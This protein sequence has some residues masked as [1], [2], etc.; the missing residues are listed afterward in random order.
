MFRFKLYHPSFN[1]PVT[2]QNDP[3]GWDAE[4]K[5]I[6]RD[7]VLHGVFVKYNPELKFVKD[8][9]ALINE[10][11]NSYGIEAEITLTVERKNVATRAWELQYEG[12][13]E[14]ITFKTDRNFTTV[15]TMDTGFYQKFKNRQDVKVNLQAVTDQDGN[16]M[17]SFADISLPLH[18][19]TIR[20]DSVNRTIEATNVYTGIATGTTYYLLYSFDNEITDELGE[21]FTY[22]PQLST[23]DPVANLKHYFVVKDNGSYE[24]NIRIDQYMSCAVAINW[25]VKW[26]LATGRVGNYTITQIGTTQSVFNIAADQQF[27]A[28]ITRTLAA[29]DEVYL[30]A[31]VVINASGPAT[32]T[33]NYNLNTLRYSEFSVRGSTVSDSSNATATLIHDVWKRV[34]RS[35]TGR[36]NSFKSDYYGRTEDGYAADGAGSLRAIT[37]GEQ[38]RGFSIS[39]YPIYASAKNLFDSCSAID[40]VGMGLEKVN[41]FNRIAVEPLSYFYRNVKAM[42][43]SFVNDI[44]RSVAQEYLFNEVEAGYNI[45]NNRGLQI[46]NLDEVNAKRTYSLPIARVKKKL[47]LIS[48]YIASGYCIEFARR[49]ASKKTTDAEKDKENFIIQLR[50]SPALVPEKNEAASQS[51]VIDTASSYNARLSPMQNLV[52][53]GARIRGGLPNQDI[54]QMSFGEGNNEATT[55]V[56]ANTFN[57]K[58]IDVASLPKPFWKAEYYEFM[59]APSSQDWAAFELQPY[60]FIEFS[61]NNRDYVKGWLISAKPD[62]D[63]NRVHFKLLAAL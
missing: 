51:N 37:S 36:E 58:S 9:R 6:E 23:L 24:F 39:T 49:L 52:R 60:G 41:G 31:T 38:L 59:A 16:A 53:N 11:F 2:L 14:M 62:A 46:N 20:K 21:R 42:R 12:I 15:K 45:W 22:Q 61:A 40:G 43:L 56:G 35:C 10:L 3:M 27:T 32:I 55:I 1:K 17:P 29:N 48:P 13:L 28:T 63:S 57:E 47:T 44:Q 34:V 50:R 33:H 25:E 7:P 54:I 19:K 5:S 8:G 18:S 30:Y 4:R 26:Y